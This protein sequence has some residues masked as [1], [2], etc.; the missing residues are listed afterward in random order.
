MFLLVLVLFLF[1][2]FVLFCFNLDFAM[3]CRCASYLLLFFNLVSSPLGVLFLRVTTFVAV[4][5]AT[6]KSVLDKMLK[7]ACIFFSRGCFRPHS[8]S[9][10]ITAFFWFLDL[11]LSGLSL[12]L[13]DCHFLWIN[14]SVI[15]ARCCFP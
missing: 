5:F 2:C 8:S 13:Y 4:V 14:V 12:P 15:V 3:L 11:I 1:F 6:L 7:V 10:S 9:C